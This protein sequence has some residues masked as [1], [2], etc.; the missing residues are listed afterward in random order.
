[1]AVVFTLVFCIGVALCLLQFA[2]A[3][4]RSPI[5]LL[6]AHSEES[7]GRLKKTLGAA[8]IFNEAP[9]FIVVTGVLSAA[10]IG[11]IFAAL[12]GNA[13]FILLGPIVVAIAG[14]FYLNHKQKAMVKTSGDML[15]PFI[16]HI[17][18]SVLAGTPVP[19]S[20]QLAVLDS[21]PSLRR[22]LEDSLSEMTTGAPF[23]EALR[24][25]QE[26]LPLRMWKIFVRQMEIHDESG[27]DLSKS[28]S[29]T[30]EHID[31]MVSLQK[32]GQAQYASF[33]VQQ[34]IALFLGGVVCAFFMTRLSYEQLSQLWTNPLGIIGLL[35][36]IGL[37]AA[38]F[39][40][41]RRALAS[42]RT[43]INF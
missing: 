26:R 27:G 16:R 17:Q 25:T 19:K 37:I 11:L 28:M 13:V 15:V 32:L 41:S 8:G 39:F 4:Y 2:P 29:A 43:R 7:V 42:I 36:G 9:T 18:S 1:M 6:A 35:F 10:A 21:P 33:A 12:F 3:Y 38:G 20:Y 40:V 31:A 5:R 24:R 14:F 22:V 34:K 30:V 23:I